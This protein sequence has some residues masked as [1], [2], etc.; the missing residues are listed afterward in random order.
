MM[1]WSCGTK[2]KPPAISG[3]GA[4]FRSD[5]ITRI[6]ILKAIPAI[7][8]LISAG[9]KR[10]LGGAAAAIANHFVHLAR[11]AVPTVI[12][13]LVCPTG[14]TAA[15]FISEALLSKKGLFRSSKGEFGATIAAD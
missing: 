10:H 14:R 8:G 9:L 5:L 3:K 7:N 13:T 12:I 6:L 15:W 2:V 11:A 4:L 1:L